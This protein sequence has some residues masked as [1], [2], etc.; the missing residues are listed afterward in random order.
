[1]R[2]SHFLWGWILEYIPVILSGLTTTVLLIYHCT[3]SPPIRP[4]R[5]RV[6][7][8]TTLHHSRTENSTTAV[9]CE[10]SR[11]FL[12][13]G[14]TMSSVRMLFSLES[15]WLIRSPRYRRRIRACVRNLC[16]GA[17]N[18]VDFHNDQRRSNCDRQATRRV[19][20]SRGRHLAAKR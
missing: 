11:I 4:A 17:H 16:L 14:R 9:R 8:P 19:Y 18:R 10:R 5:S 3:V 15:L 20:Q 6:S 13:T 7:W 1:M 12:R 2:G